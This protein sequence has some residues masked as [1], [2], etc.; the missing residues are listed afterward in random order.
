V[1]TGLRQ[2]THVSY[3]RCIATVL[4]ATISYNIPKSE[5]MS[6]N[7]S[8]V[9]RTFKMDLILAMMY[10]FPFSSETGIQYRIFLSSLCSYISRLMAE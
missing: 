2:A 7:V 9:S 4:R 5:V 6:L 8:V 10:L 1:F 3:D